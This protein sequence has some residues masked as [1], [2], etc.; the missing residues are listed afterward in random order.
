MRLL[1]ISVCLILPGGL[2]CGEGFPG[3]YTKV[4][5]YK[6]WINCIIEMSLLYDNNQEQVEEACNRRAGPKSDCLASED[7]VADCEAYYTDSND[8][9]LRVQTC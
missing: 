8:L 9:G 5:F 2:G 1:S 4:E 6:D 3:W 7:K